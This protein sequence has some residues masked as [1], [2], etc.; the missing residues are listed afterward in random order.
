MKLVVRT[1]PIWFY[2]PKCVEQEF[3]EVRAARSYAK[4]YLMY[5]VGGGLHRT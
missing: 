4:R 3:S 5:A 2:S 1:P